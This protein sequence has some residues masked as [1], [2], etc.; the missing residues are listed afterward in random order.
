[1][2]AL[3]LHTLRI[4][5]NQIHQAINTIDNADMEIIWVILNMRLH[6]TLNL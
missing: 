1:M 4:S 5:S 3:Y 2:F 6:G